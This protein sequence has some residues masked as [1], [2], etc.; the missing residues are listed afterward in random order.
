[1]MQRFFRS[2]R[3]D[4]F[5]PRMA[6]PAARPAVQPQ[7]A[8]VVRR[9]AAMPAAAPASA[10][11]QIQR[12]APAP[13]PMAA[14]PAAQAQRNYAADLAQAQQGPMLANRAADARNL[15][16]AAPQGQ[17]IH[18][19][20]A[21]AAA[22]NVQRVAAQPMAPQNQALIGNALAQRQQAQRQDFAR[23]A[24]EDDDAPLGRFM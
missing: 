17:P 5:D 23:R 19:A 7:R 4:A 21:P 22:Q 14:P 8:A 11:P 1:M 9:P 15:M 18:A 16:A 10:R 13:A 20:P 3:P 2:P 24:P 6:R 12:Q